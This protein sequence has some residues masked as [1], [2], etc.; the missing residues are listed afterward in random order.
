MLVLLITYALTN[1]ELNIF[2]IEP[3]NEQD[4]TIEDLVDDF[5][6]FYGA[7][8]LTTA[9]LL[10]FALIEIILHPTILDR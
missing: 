4:F 7:G 8:Q 10:S 9:S 3:V 5:V 6:G 1:N 2:V